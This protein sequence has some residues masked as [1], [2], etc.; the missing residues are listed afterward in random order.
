MCT[1]IVCCVLGYRV[2]LMGFLVVCFNPICSIKINI[3][4]GNRE[5]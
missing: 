2:V 1:V 5:L 4:D 3:T